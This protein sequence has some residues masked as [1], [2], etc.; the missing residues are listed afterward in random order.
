MHEEARKDADTDNESDRAGEEDKQ[1]A[2]A[3]FGKGDKGA[4]SIGNENLQPD[5][6]LR[7]QQTFCRRL[8][9]HC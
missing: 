3:Q 8:Y 9:S 6:I 4:V 7:K 1:K 5:K 2:P